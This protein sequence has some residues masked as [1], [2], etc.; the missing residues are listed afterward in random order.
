ML[1]GTMGY[2]DC[3]TILKRL[4][5]KNS[6]SRLRSVSQSAFR[7]NMLIDSSLLW[8]CE[9]NTPSLGTQWALRSL[10]L[11]VPWIGYPEHPLFSSLHGGQGPCQVLFDISVLSQLSQYVWNMM[12]MSCYLNAKEPTL[13]GSPKRQVIFILS[14][15]GPSA[16]RLLEVTC[17]LGSILL[18]MFLERWTLWWKSLRTNGSKEKSN[19]IGATCCPRKARR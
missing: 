19:N 12:M 9:S 6:V 16:S 10:G 5:F 3:L 13:W 11:S 7:R 18:E 8:F 15:S 1:I 2:L 14:S 4:W 17:S